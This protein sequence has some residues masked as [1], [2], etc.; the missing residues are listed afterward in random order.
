M[1]SV[2]FKRSSSGGVKFVIFAISQIL[3]TVLLV[4]IHHGGKGGL[5]IK[6]SLA[7]KKSGFT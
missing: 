3:N 1:G 2:Y 7:P 5:D 4:N 6:P